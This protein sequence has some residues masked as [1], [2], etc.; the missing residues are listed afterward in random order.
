MPSILDLVNLEFEAAF[1]LFVERGGLD[2]VR[3]LD[4]DWE[5]IYRHQ[6]YCQHY[7]PRRDCSKCY[8]PSP[9]AKFQ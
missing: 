7:I 3:Y 5:R 1:Q 9:L 2:E 6:V 8:R 4:E